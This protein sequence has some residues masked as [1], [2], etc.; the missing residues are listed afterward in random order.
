M[1]T[2]PIVME[3]KMGGALL[4]YYI[5]ITLQIEWNYV[6]KLDLLCLQQSRSS[7]YENVFFCLSVS[8]L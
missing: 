5:I 3:L 8:C 6:H 4:F 1:L 7:P 2:H